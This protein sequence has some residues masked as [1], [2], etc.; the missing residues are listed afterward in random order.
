VDTE[1]R[2]REI[3]AKVRRE[4]RDAVVPHGRPDSTLRAT[5]GETMPTTTTKPA[6]RKAQAGLFR[7]VN[8][9]M[10]ALLALP[11]PTPPGNRLMLVHHIGRK[12]GKHYR[13]PVSYVRDGD[14]LLTPGGGN[15]T[16]NLRDSEPVHIRLRGRDITA[17]PQLI[18]DPTEVERLLGVMA[19][20]NP[21][22]NRFVPIPKTDDGKL[23]PS[24]L[25]RALKHGFRIV[26]WQLDQDDS[27]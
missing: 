20:A 15:W 10:R 11:F 12:T 14:T 6:R 22:L 16:R 18:G 21:M 13:Q 25:A 1:K 24:S 7:L 19:A 26:R 4:Q 27:R 9:P 23:D 17:R 5:N 3:K 8:V 2:K